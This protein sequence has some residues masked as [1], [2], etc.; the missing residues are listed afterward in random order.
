[1]F[2]HPKCS[3]VGGL[4]LAMVT[5]GVQAADDPHIRGEIT[6]IEGNLYSV[7]TTSGQS[8]EVQLN[9]DATVLLYSPLEL[10]DIEADDYLGIPSAPAP[11]G[12]KRALAVVVFPE[13]MRGFNEGEGAWDLVPGSRMTN[14]TLAQV[15]ANDNAGTLTVK[16]GDKN[17]EILVPANTPVVTFAPAPERDVRVGEQAIF[18]AKETAAGYTAGLVGVSEDGSLP[19]I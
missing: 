5:A 16:Y 1:M 2:Q 4:V 11:G 6:A 13:A 3:L 12:G 15:T 10:S 14:A 9:A 18:F 8:V 19:P 7:E 17:E